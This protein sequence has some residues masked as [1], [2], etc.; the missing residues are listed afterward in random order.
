M[1]Y[2]HKYACRKSQFNP[3][4]TVSFKI[5]WKGEQYGH[6]EEYT[7]ENKYRMLRSLVSIKLNLLEAL[8]IRDEYEANITADSR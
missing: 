5:E 6:Y 7:P 4:P 8:Q 3:L 2:P 1:K